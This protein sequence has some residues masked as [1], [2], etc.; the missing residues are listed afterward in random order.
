MPAA[1]TEYRTNY[2]GGGWH[3]YRKIA[4]G[5]PSAPTARL[6]DKLGFHHGSVVTHNS[7][8]K[9][10]ESL[11]SQTALPNSYTLSYCQTAYNLMALS[12]SIQLPGV[13]LTVVA[14][15]SVDHPRKVVPGAVGLAVL[16]IVTVAVVND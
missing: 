6:Q 12:T 3:S 14:E 2:R 15:G 4:G 9:N 10:P 16:I 7:E 1:T 5:L 13:K 11:W 8:S